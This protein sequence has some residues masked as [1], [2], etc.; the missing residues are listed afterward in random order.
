MRIEYGSCALCWVM[1]RGAGVD[2]DVMDVNVLD[3]GVITA[4]PLR[5]FPFIRIEPTEINALLS[6]HHF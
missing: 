3:I 2:I 5:L 4:F 6:L 1:M